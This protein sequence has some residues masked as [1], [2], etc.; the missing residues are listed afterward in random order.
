M[1]FVDQELSDSSC[2]LE[3]LEYCLVRLLFYVK[4][5]RQGITVTNLKTS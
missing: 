1:V 3:T 2:D 5:C 4:V